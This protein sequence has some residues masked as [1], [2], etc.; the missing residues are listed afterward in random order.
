MPD[1][2][3]PIESRRTPAARLLCRRLWPS[4]R[5]AVEAH[6]L[7]LDSQTRANRF[8]AAI[9]DHGALAYAAR[10][11][12]HAGVMYGAFVN[13]ALRGVGE[14]RP[15]GPRGLGPLGHRAEAAFA[16]E[17]GYRRRG[18]GAMLFRRVVGAARHRGVADLHVRCL[19]ANAPMRNLARKLGAELSLTGPETDGTIRLATP[20]PFS[21]W[22]ES[23]VEA[24][25]LTLANAAVTPTRQS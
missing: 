24:F 25:D 9:G 20:T 7:R 16:I 18:L 1:R 5:R 17:R 13:G 23:L 21:L 3:V 10:S 4:D 12:D 14:L 15:G 6:F 8:M 11:F 19:T 2:T 22:R